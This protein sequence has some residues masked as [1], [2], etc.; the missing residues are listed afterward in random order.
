MAVK[1]VIDLRNYN[2]KSEGPLELT[3]E[4]EFYWDQMLNPAIEGD[5]GVLDYIPVPGSWYRLRKVNPEVTRYGF[6]TYRLVI[7]LPEG[8]DDV[9]FQMEDVFSASGYFLNG[10]VIDF[11]GFPGVNKYQTLTK[12]SRPLV[13]GS[14]TGTRAELLVKVSNFD[15]MFSG[16]LGGITIGLPEQMRQQ[17][18]KELFHGHFLI[19]A[20][21][22][23]GIYFL[24]LYLIRSEHYRLYFALL[25]ILMALR[26]SIILELP[27]IESLHMN[28]LSITRIDFLNIYF[29]APFF[30]LMIRSIF[31]FEFPGWIFRTVMWISSLFIIIVVVSPIS[32]FSYHVAMVFYF[33]PAD[34]P[35]FSL[36]GSYGL[37]QG[38]EPCTCVHHRFADPLRGY[39]E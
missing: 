2:F 3:G 24:G 35:C 34:Q 10:K 13:T 23:I 25:C 8:V 5:S 9:S 36:C 31:P 39:A 26:V 14:V 30:T 18:D 27:V 20:F 29:F 7:L 1:G 15:H 12:Y 37:E 4:Y 38:Q 17:R 22:I 32:L 33:L 21:L 19:G 28:G 6:A 16:I 11:L